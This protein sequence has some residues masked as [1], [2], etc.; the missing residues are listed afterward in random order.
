MLDASS[1]ECSRFQR[2]RRRWLSLCSTRVFGVV[3][4]GASPSCSA[5]GSGAAGCA[6]PLGITAGLSAA[7]SDN[8]HVQRDD[9]GTL[10]GHIGFTEI[11][12][13]CSKPSVGRKVHFMSA[14]PGVLDFFDGTTSVNPVTAGTVTAL[15]DDTSN[16]GAT[17][18]SD[19]GSSGS[20]TWGHTNHNG[21]QFDGE[22]LWNHAVF[23][24][25]ARH[26]IVGLDSNRWECD[27]GPGV[28][29]DGSWY[30]YVR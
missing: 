14:T 6:N 18:G 12:F 27:D 28:V 29:G 24:E 2:P 21:G 26:W 23:V 11:R 9:L 16:L 13:E 1:A 7:A 19:W 25:G 8:G 10:R 3:L 15:V 4:A 17:L 22:Q 5:N 30:I 20:A